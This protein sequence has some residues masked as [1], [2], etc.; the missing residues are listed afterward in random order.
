MTYRAL[1]A[2]AALSLLGGC[3]V[4]SDVAGLASGAGAA[5]ATGN[6]AL[7][8]FVG[9]GV[10]AGADALRK[11]V[12]RVRRHGEQDAIAD[13]AGTAPLGEARAWE[14]RHTIPIGNTRG[15]VTAVREITTPLATC[16]EVAFSLS[17]APSRPF[18]TTL[19]R[20][21]ERW[22]W[23]AAEPAVERWGLLQ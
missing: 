10:Q 7:G 12:V 1:A 11:Y 23:A 19:C 15:T 16:R 17:D 18:V 8:F 5:A 14:I 9:V 6:P 21:E 3:Q 2:L 13:A 4:V 20:Q 22:S